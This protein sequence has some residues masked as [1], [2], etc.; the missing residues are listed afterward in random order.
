MEPFWNRDLAWEMPDTG[1]GTKMMAAEFLVGEGRP[2]LDSARSVV[3]AI[4]ADS[5]YLADR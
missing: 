5:Q 3:H 2:S 1:M 4:L